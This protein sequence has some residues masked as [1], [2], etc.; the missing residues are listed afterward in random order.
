[1]RSDPSHASGL[2]VELSPVT[3]NS[4]LAS[5]HFVSLNI[6]IVQKVEEPA[7]AHK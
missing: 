6:R 3:N 2:V 4:L 7:T 5:V 1:M